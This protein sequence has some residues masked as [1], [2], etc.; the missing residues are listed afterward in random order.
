MLTRKEVMS[1]KKNNNHLENGIYIKFL[2][3]SIHSGERTV[4]SYSTQKLH[5]FIYL[6]IIYLLCVCVCVGGI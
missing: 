4:S 2:P 1:E 3:D 6:F 5:L